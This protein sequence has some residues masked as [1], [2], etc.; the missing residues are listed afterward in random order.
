[1]VGGHP[2]AAVLR[3]PKTYNL[4]SA[5]FC[6]LFSI[7][8]MSFW[9]PAILKTRS[10]NDTLQLGGYAAETHHLWPYFAYH[11]LDEHWQTECKRS[12]ALI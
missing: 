8:A 10:V 6:I 11:C 9:L 1:M 3:D 5:C 12:S 7:S 4:A 2:R